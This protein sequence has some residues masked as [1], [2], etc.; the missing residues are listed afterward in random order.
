MIG[1]EYT[2]K[3]V[4]VLSG[5]VSVTVWLSFMLYASFYRMYVPAP[6]ISRP[7]HFVFKICS[8][9]VGICSFPTANITLSPENQAKILGRGQQYLVVLALDVPDSHSNRDLGQ[10]MVTIKVYDRDQ[11]FVQESARAVTLRYQSDLLKTI[12]TIILS[13]LYITGFTEQTQHLTIELFDAFWDDYYR[14]AVGVVLELQSFQLTFYS[15]Q[16]QFHAR[17]SGLRYYMYYY[18]LASAVFGVLFNCG[19]VSV[20]FTLSWYKLG[21]E[22]L[23]SLH[24]TAVTGIQ[25]VREEGEGKQ[26][27]PLHS[28]PPSS[29]QSPPAT[30][31]LSHEKKRIIE[32]EDDSWESNLSPKSFIQ[33]FTMNTSIHSPETIGEKREEIPSKTD[34]RSSDSVLRQR[35]KLGELPD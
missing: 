17:Y 30:P 6:S 28:H 24:V 8:S 20:L 26:P 4:F 7:A 5:I 33:T 27:L 15:A 19:W 9:G 34:E 11:D 23:D 31:E 22:L 25:A 3:R 1:A 32:E 12:E 29:P 13:P 18:P 14:P 10:F 35:L 2:A 21:L 16:L